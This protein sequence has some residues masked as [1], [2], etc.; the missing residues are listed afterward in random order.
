VI[1]ATDVSNWLVAGSTVVYVVLTA[2]LVMLG[3]RQARRDEVSLIAVLSDRWARAQD[4]WMKAMLVARG[5]TNYYNIAAPEETARYEGLLADLADLAAMGPGRPGW[6]GR[7]QALANRSR[8]YESA[9][10]AVIEQLASISLLVL[11]GRLSTGGAY[12][13]LGPQLVRNAGSLRILLVRHRGDAGVVSEPARRVGGWAQYRPGVVRRVLV[14]V[15]LLWAEAARLGDL[16][17]FELASAADA[18]A[19]EPPA[20]T[21]VACGERCAGC[22]RRP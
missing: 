4:D 12:A 8:E 10:A 11:R 7:H 19:Q 20:G 16:A 9:A 15:D 14:L 13:V 21:A 5:P 6:S 17:P 18:K 3:L 1:A 2:G 22:L